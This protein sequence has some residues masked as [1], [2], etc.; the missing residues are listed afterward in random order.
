VLE[1]EIL[2]NLITKERKIPLFYM[3]LQ[4]VNWKMLTT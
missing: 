1:I 3:W 4:F 2:E